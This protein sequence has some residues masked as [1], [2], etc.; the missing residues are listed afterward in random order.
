MSSRLCLTVLLPAAGYLQ[1]GKVSKHHDF[2]ALESDRFRPKPEDRRQA[3]PKLSRRT[4]ADNG[5]G[6]SGIAG[7]AEKRF[8]PHARGRYCAGRRL[9]ISRRERTR[10]TGKAAAL[11]A[12]AFFAVIGQ[13][14]AAPIELDDPAIYSACPGT[15]LAALQM[16]VNPGALADCNQGRAA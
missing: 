16:Q 15:G 3:A 8:D 1:S 13:K 4:L 6:R 5:R 7:F 11:P 10:R 9:A 14:T 12:G 2:H